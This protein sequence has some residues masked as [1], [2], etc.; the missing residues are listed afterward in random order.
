MWACSNHPLVGVLPGRSGAGI[1]WPVA[2]SITDGSSNLSIWRSSVRIMLCCLS[3]VKVVLRSGRG[4]GGSGPA[5]SSA[6]LARTSKRPAK[7]RLFFLLTVV[8]DS[9][10]RLMRSISAAGRLRKSFRS[11]S[12]ALRCF[13][14][15]SRARRSAAAASS[16]RLFAPFLDRDF[17][18]RE[19]HFRAS[20]KPTL[21]Q[22]ET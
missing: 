18:V 1:F 6:C 19:A 9:S 12:L 5:S 17:E 10:S 3:A 14:I 2:G 4:F 8:P 7:S 22:L 21:V 15:A 20:S 16:S 13:S 11:A